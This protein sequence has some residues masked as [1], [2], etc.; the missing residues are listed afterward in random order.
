LLTFSNGHFLL[1]PLYMSPASLL[2]ELFHQN[3]G[4]FSSL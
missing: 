2:D 1:T 4:W 3:A